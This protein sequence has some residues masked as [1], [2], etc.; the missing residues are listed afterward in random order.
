MLS[1]KQEMEGNFELLSKK[2]SL[3]LKKRK[4]IEILTKDY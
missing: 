2:E 4:V 3:S 1:T